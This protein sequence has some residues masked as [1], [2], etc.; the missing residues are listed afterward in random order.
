MEA[1]HNAFMEATTK[2]QL[3]S[4]EESIHRIKLKM[5]QGIV[6]HYTLTE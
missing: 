5:R 1:Y 3:E 4:A 2:E 6:Y